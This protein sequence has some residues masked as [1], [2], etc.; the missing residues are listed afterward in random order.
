MAFTGPETV[1]RKLAEL[2]AAFEALAR[3]YPKIQAVQDE[4]ARYR[5]W[6][7][8]VRSTLTASFFPSTIADEFDSWRDRY[9]LAFEGAQK[10]APNVTPRAPSP[11]AL[12][13]PEPQTSPWIYVAVTG[14]IA[15]GLVAVARLLK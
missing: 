13:G 10:A 8:K 4:T 7:E 1:E 6:L 14:S 9:K 11:E 12:S 3:S 5:V 2:D 15:L